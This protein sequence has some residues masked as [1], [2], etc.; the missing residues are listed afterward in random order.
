ME[1][2]KKDLIIGLLV[3]RELNPADVCSIVNGVE[4]VIDS[5]Y[6]TFTEAVRDFE[7]WTNQFH[8]TELFEVKQTEH[9]FKASVKSI[10]KCRIKP[11]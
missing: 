10:L 8:G 3:E 1:K 9:E 4:M 11:R 6:Q 7:E 5:E 2:R